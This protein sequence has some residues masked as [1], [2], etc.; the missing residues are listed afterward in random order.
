MAR[1]PRT[2]GIFPGWTGFFPREKSG[3]F[4]GEI[5]LAHQERG[6]KSLTI[7]FAVENYDCHLEQPSRLIARWMAEA[8]TWIQT[9]TLPPDHR[10]VKVVSPTKPQ[11]KLRRVWIVLGSVEDTKMETCKDTKME[12]SFFLL[13][14]LQVSRRIKVYWSPV[15]TLPV[16]PLWCDLGIFPNS[17][18]TKAAANLSP[19]PSINITPVTRKQKVL[20]A[21][22]AIAAVPLKDKVWWEYSLSFSSVTDSI[23]KLHNN[24]QFCQKVRFPVRSS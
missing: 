17:R 1:R 22:P 18:S 6:P 15:R 20:T 8:Q 3:E 9:W 11:N 5:R 4:E 21:Q 12:T 23:C 14:I 10:V 16:A 24:I 7:G 19:P 13:L 2:T